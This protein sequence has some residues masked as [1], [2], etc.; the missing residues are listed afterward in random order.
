MQR[1]AIKELME[2]AEFCVNF[3]KSQ[4]PHWVGAAGCYGYPGALLLFSIV[5]SLGSIVEGGGDDVSKHFKVL[6]NPDWYAYKFE[7]EEL[8]LLEQSYRNKL[9]HNAHI[10]AGLKMKPGE[11]PDQVLGR[12]TVDGEYVLSLVPFLERTRTVVEKFLSEFN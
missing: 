2:V 8:K 7:S 5:D 9:V 1:E 10:K 11:T 12:D 4:D 6:N 3:D